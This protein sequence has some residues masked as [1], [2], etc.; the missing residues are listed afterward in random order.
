MCL[1]IDAHAM[2]LDIE[3]PRYV[4]RYRCARARC[5]DIIYRRPSYVHRYKGAKLCV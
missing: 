1:D 3:A 2:C 4:F 5:L